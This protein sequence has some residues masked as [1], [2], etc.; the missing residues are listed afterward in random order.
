M[1]WY[2]FVTYFET[3]TKLF[4]ISTYLSVL[5]SPLKG[6]SD[7]PARNLSGFETDDTMHS[8]MNM[9]KVYLELT[10]NLGFPGVGRLIM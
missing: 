3:Q 10:T 5:V 6:S 7:C 8:Q 1:K 9:N 4:V 2:M